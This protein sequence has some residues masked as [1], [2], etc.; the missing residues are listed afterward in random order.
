MESAR[1]LS[2]PGADR[3]RPIADARLSAVGAC[4]TLMARGCRGLPAVADAGKKFVGGDHSASR[5]APN[6]RRSLGVAC[7]SEFAN[8][9]LQ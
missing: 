4:G 9:S 7:G 2:T 1:A 6:W 3:R 8:S 5:A